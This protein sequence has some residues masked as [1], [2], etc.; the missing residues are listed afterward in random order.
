MK[1]IS[2][3]TCCVIDSGLFLHVAQRLARDVKKVYY[4]TP[5]E[6]SFQTVRKGC[7]GDGFDEFQ[8]VD[9]FWRIKHQCDFFVFPHI[10]FSSIQ[11]ELK[12]QG[13]PTW[14]PCRA[15]EFEFGRGKFLELLEKCN[16][17][18][19]PYEVIKGMDKL[20][21][22]LEDKE[23][24]WI[25]VSRWRQDFETMHWRSW[26]LD[27]TR[28]DYFATKF[29]SLKNE[30][31]FYVFD[32]IETEIEIGSDG[33]FAGGKFPERTFQG[34][35]SKDKAYLGN[36]LDSSDLPIPLQKVNAA[37]TPTL[38]EYGYGGF[39]STEIRCVD[40]DDFYF[41]DI[42]E[43][44]G[45]PPS[46]VMDEML[47]NYGEI[48]AGGANGICVEPVEAAKFG[49]QLYVK[50]KRL[51][52]EWFEVELPKE[53]EQW[54]KPMFCVRV[55][56]KLCWPPDKDNPDR[57]SDAGWLVSNGDTIEE[58]L[59]SLKSYIEE[60][61]EGLEADISPMAALFEEAKLAQ[62]SGME[63]TDDKIPKPSS[64]VETK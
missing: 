56:G 38:T 17:K 47:G 32:P 50:L 5:T 58:C 33:W 10:G 40:E 42:T 18:V 20:R 37:I 41:T 13:I 1:P 35:E 64:V 14:G 39:I 7:I 44:C 12:S 6:M 4:W 49:M 63:I 43:R 54:F 30:I 36:F 59:E 8:R 9:D 16:L 61:P 34:M 46:E 19:P 57:E 48:I 26:K 55:D 60:L 11:M 3:Q 31:K 2:E 51:P 15:D 27:N 25:K 53:L 22:H 24:K 21:I 52:G 23:D 62:E 28:L 45:S 29:G